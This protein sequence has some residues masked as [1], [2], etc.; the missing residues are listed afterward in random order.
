MTSYLWLLAVL[1]LKEAAV[2]SFIKFLGLRSVESS[3]LN[4]KQSIN[5]RLCALD[6]LKP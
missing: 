6:Y 3:D 2:L 1:G 4:M 5:R